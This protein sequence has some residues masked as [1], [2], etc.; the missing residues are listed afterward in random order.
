[1]GSSPNTDA[2]NVIAVPGVPVAGEAT[3]TVVLVIGAGFTGAGL[4]WFN[5]ETTQG[6]PCSFAIVI[7]KSSLL[8][9]ARGG[10]LAVNPGRHRGICRIAAQGADVVG[11]RVLGEVAGSISQIN[12]EIRCAGSI[13]YE[14][15]VRMAIPVHVTRCKRLRIGILRQRHSVEGC[16]LEGSIAISRIKILGVETASRIPSPL[17]S[18]RAA[19][20]TTP[21]E[22]A[23]IV[24]G[25]CLKVPSPFPRKTASPQMKSSFPSLFRSPTRRPGY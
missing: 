22:A 21:P 18:A 9:L 13:L 8:S 11:V 4:V 10:S 7:N 20:P 2:V 3:S 14:K 5:K 15:Q 17:R 12:C 24:S 6:L 19:A 16:G 25:I 1:M 23:G